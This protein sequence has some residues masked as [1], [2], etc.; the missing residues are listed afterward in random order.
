MRTFK[1]NDPAATQLCAHCIRII[2]KIKN[3]DLLIFFIYNNNDE[4]KIKLN[5]T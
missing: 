5:K 2:K 4:K 3:K 1:W